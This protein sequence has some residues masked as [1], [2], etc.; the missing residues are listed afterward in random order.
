LQGVHPK[1]NY[2]TATNTKQTGL[3]LTTT[4]FGLRK[5]T[6]IGTWNIRTLHQQPSKSQQLVREFKKSKLTILGVS[7][8]RW[9][10]SGEIKWQT[11]SGNEHVSFLYSGKPQDQTR[12]SGVGFLLSAEARRAMIDWNAVSDRIITAKFRSRARTIAVVQCYA[13]TNE[14]DSQTKDNFYELLSATLDKV[15]KGNIKIIMGDFNAKVG[16][17]N[18]NLERI[19]GKQGVGT[20]SDNGERFVEL[21]NHHDMVIGGTLFDHKDIHKVT[22]YSNDGRTR[23]QI[24]HI[25]ISHKW[26]RSLLDAR[27]FRGAELH[28]DHKLLIGTIQLKLAANKR[29][30][31]ISRRTTDPKRLQDPRLLRQF[32]QEVSTSLGQLCYD[33]PEQRWESVRAAYMEAAVRVI[34][35]VPERKKCYISD[36]T[37]EIIQERKEAGSRLDEAS[38]QSEYL[39]RL[40]VYNRLERRVK[41][42]ARRDRRCWLNETAEQASDAA[43][44]NQL[45][46]FYRLTRTLAGGFKPVERPVKAVDGALITSEDLKLQRWTQYFR[47]ALNCSN[48]RSPSLVTDILNSD[49]NIPQ[50]RSRINIKVPSI[51]EVRLAIQSLKPG[52]APGPDGLCVE[53]F[54]ADDKMAATELQPLIEAF[55][56]LEEIPEA[57]KQ[58]NLVKLP[59]KGDLSLCENWRGIALL[60]SINKIISSIIRERISTEIEPQLRK[61][62]SGF[63]KGRSRIDQINA[64]RIIVEQSCEFNSPL[65]MLF[66][67]FKQAFDCVDQEAMWKILARYGVPAKL[68]A[69]IKELYRDANL[70]VVHQSMIGPGFVVNSG[71]KQGCILSPLLFNIV[72][73]FVMRIV[74][75]KKRGIQ[76]DPF[77]RLSDLDYADDLVVLTHS[78]QECQEFLDDL[79]RVAKS[80]GLTINAKKTKLMRT[81]QQPTTRR[82]IQSIKIEEDTIEEV[83]KFIYL[84]SVIARDGG[85]SEDVRNRIQL[86]NIAFGKL[87]HVWRSQQYSE[88]LK[89]KLFDSNVKSVLLSGCETWRV[90]KRTSQQLQ[91]CVN[92]CLRKICG[93]FYPDL[94]S[95]EALHERTRQRPVTDEI[96]RRKWNWIGHT[97]RKDPEDLTRQ[98]L[99]WNPP[100]KRNK[101]RPRITWQSSVRAEAAQQKYEWK[102]VA[103][104]AKNRVRF[105]SF[106]N[107]LHF[108]ETE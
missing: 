20:R 54:K 55:W 35:K 85:T 68:I 72:L 45:G 46:E 101:G 41:T 33:E 75:K 57:C 50:P 66:I 64:L 98:A 82:A 37:W 97:L 3:D 107:A 102:E 93:I 22:W 15:N 14:A 67:D 40:E 61:E 28:T 49:V 79:V 70:Q 42:S 96:G 39:E 44:K 38:S 11:D 9:A 100:G 8:H 21:C 83:E 105:R 6:R 36:A 17:D 77:N 94:I 47:Q 78:M 76:W 12:E 103:A 5:R 99:S 53:L 4:T 89:L 32:K 43:A 81:S 59:K 87:G 56:D 51:A 90:T 52:K 62:Q 24:D 86:A 58:A 18:N 25:A 60:N 13:P 106:V 30:A 71:V 23:N 7:E 34:P 2:A 26:K 88:K 19:M 27:V 16:V 63:R 10:D 1:F 48:S 31:A 74:N 73:D 65:C 108:G 69:I 80:V 92:K 91:A 84:G 29:N 104:L 95:N